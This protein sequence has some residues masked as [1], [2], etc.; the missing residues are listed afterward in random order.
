MRI[1]ITAMPRVSP[2]AFETLRRLLVSALA[3]ALAAI[4][5]ACLVWYVTAHTNA[6]MI[7]QQQEMVLVDQFDGS[8]AELDSSMSDFMDSLVDREIGLG[9]RKSLRTAISLHAA[10]AQRLS[11][12][13]G[14]APIKQYTAGLGKLRQMVDR[15]TDIEDGVAAA[16]LHADILANKKRISDAAWE[17]V[18]QK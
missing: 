8:G 6:Q 11:N 9:V 18:R 15:T 1:V 2:Q 16:R 13:I 17:R 5:G 7:A 10:K 12:I 4:F 14:D 3:P